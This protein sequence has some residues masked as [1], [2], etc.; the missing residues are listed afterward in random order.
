MYRNVIV[1]LTAIIFLACSSDDDPVDCETSGPVINLESVT[2]ATT[3]AANDGSIRVSI[4]GGTEPYSFFANNQAVG[5][6]GE[7]KN[8]QAGSYSVSVRDANNCTAALGNITVLSQDF[9]FTTS[10]QPNTSCLGG[11]GSVSIDVVNTNPPYT[12]QLANGSFTSDNFFSGLKKGNHIITVKDNN[13]CTVTLSI[14]IPQGNSGTSWTNDIKPI[15]EKNCAISGCHNGVSR[16]NN[17]SEYASA[18]LHSKNIKS[19]TQDR[20]MPF[21]GSLSQN[22]I[23]LIACWVDDGALQ[24]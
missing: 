15:M 6:A 7:I 13:N 16:S 5:S 14:T 10:L 22:Q 23:D 20:S 9:S 4:A 17:F 24:N 1:V 2:D 8:L 11:N 21:D 3:C 18:K 19:K 12:F